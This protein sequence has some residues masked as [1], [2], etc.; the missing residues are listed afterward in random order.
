MLPS[1]DGNLFGDGC[2]VA[3]R[4]DDSRIWVD[5][6][7]AQSATK[8]CFWQECSPSEARLC[9]DFS[10]EFDVAVRASELT[11]E[12]VLYPSLGCEV[13]LVPFNQAHGQSGIHFFE[14]AHE[15]TVTG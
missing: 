5:E 13:V 2:G 15:G 6:E 9:V 7:P 11:V 14:H 10:L 12:R 8:K 3:R 1:D 4:Q